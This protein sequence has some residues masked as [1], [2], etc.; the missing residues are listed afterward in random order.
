VKDWPLFQ[1]DWSANSKSVFVPSVTPQGNPVILEVDQA[2]KT[3][4]VLQGKANANFVAMIQSPDGH[5]GLLLEVTPAE[6]N[7]WMVEN[8]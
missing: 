4:V 5:Y 7:A 6:N 2:G 1:G 8:F 3:N